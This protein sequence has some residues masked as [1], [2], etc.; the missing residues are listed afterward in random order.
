MTEPVLIATLKQLQDPADL[1]ILVDGQPSYITP[2]DFRGLLK[3]S[4]M[5]GADLARWL[6]VNPRTVR[7][8]IGGAPVPY[9]V[10]YTLRAKLALSNHLSAANQGKP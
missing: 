6:A 2:D 10:V 1:K 4:G 3:E 7:A 9:T 8:W 5:Q